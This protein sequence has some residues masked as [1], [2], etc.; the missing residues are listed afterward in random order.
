M[1]ERT[2]SI[3]GCENR[4][5]AWRLCSKHYQRAV[6][7]GSIIPQPPASGPDRFWAKVE[8]SDDPDGCWLWTGFVG[9][10]GYGQIGADGK[11]WHTHRYSYTIN[12]GPIPEGL[13]V[14]HRCDVPACVRPDHLFVGT[15]ADNR[16][17][18]AEKGR[19]AKGSA[20]GMNTRP[21]RRPT[22]DRSGARLHPELMP[23]GERHGNSKLTEAAVREAR[24][25]YTGAR[26]EI[27]A[28]ALEFGVSRPTMGKVLRGDAWKHA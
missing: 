6:A 17:D 1:G 18:C 23:R 11:A 3:E 19:A 15:Q 24:A 9:G 8:K 5:V 13:Y 16:R 12:V 10:F 28:L 26:G 22:G 27:T 7:N 14:C 25:R 21:D 20:N 4:R 2:C